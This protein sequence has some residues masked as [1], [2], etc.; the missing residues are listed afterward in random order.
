M[1]LENTHLQDVVGEVK[2]TSTVA[3]NRIKEVHSEIEGFTEGMDTVKQNITINQ[4]N[5]E[6]IRAEVNTITETTKEEVGEVKAQLD[7]LKDEV[8]TNKEQQAH[9]ERVLESYI[10]LQN[11]VA[12]V[13]N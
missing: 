8:A 10:A 4:D 7:V 13:E 2:E 9:D 1:K 11:T 6:D 5:I 12:L 3:Q